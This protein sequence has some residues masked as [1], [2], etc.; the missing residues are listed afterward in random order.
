MF[1]VYAFV[2]IVLA[3]FSYTQIDLNLTLLNWPSYLD[4]QKSMIQL[5]Y[6]NR[7]V[8]TIIFVII[9]IFLVVGYLYFLK[10]S[11]PSS[12][13]KKKLIRLLLIMAVVTLGA[14]SA[15]SHD[16]FNYIFDA[17]IITKYGLNP[18]QHKALDFPGDD[19]IRFM[20][21]THRTYPYG[22]AWLVITFVPS[23]LGL[24]K[25]LVTY[26]LFKLLFAFSYVISCIY[27]YKIAHI[28]GQKP[29]RAVILY[30]LHPLVI[31]DVLISPRIDSA[32]IALALIGVYTLLKNQKKLSFIAILI[33]ALIKFAS[34]LF[35]PVIMIKQFQNHKYLFSYLFVAALVTSIAQ[36]IYSHTLQPWYLLMPTAFLPFLIP[37][38]SFRKILTISM[39]FMLP[40]W[41]YIYFVNTGQWLP[42]IMY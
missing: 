34:A 7:P 10:L 41:I 1:I 23:M 2:L 17:R 39:L 16:L 19:W 25:F 3:I 22:P 15:F 4:F 33:S 36:S 32:M 14:Y 30:A 5:G 13:D 21:W 28:Q 42:V 40:L 24:G 31:F 35:L 18:Y 37:Y 12:Y 38:I 20:Q 11:A 29:E 26:L 9:F 8:N 27:I 6:F